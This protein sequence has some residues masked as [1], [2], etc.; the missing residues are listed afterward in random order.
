MKISREKVLDETTI[1][2]KA[3]LA[4]LFVGISGWLYL[5]IDNQYIGAA[6]FSLA[7]LS[8]CALDLR[9]FTSKSGYIIDS[10]RF[11]FIDLIF[12]IIGNVLGVLLVGS[13][14]LGVAKDTVIAHG[15]EYFEMK[16]NLEWYVALGT[17]VFCGIL[18]HLAGF[19]YKKV[20]NHVI[21]GLVIVGAVMT[22]L[23]AGFEHSIANV[24][25]Y[26]LGGWGWKALGYFLL[27]A[28]GNMIGAVVLELILNLSINR[29]LKIND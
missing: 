27:V 26:T 8:I 28:L 21:S 24:L 19:I 3:I 14:M 18:M 12:I 17:A 9:L 4:G 1:F 15:V 11:Y 6:I 20:N 25:Y 22:F 2:L 23:L 7:L 29:K 5:S 10:R 13:I 16:T